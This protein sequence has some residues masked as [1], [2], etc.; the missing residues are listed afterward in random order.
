MYLKTLTPAQ[1]EKYVCHEKVKRSSGLR[2]VTNEADICTVQSVCTLTD[3]ERII[4]RNISNGTKSY[5]VSPHYRRG[6]W[7]RP[8]G[9]GNDLEA[10]KTVWVRPTLVRADRVLENTLPVGSQ[11]TV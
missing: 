11:T 9:K 8:P 3:N 6:L 1:Y 7:R 5:E 10:E 4:F 2:L